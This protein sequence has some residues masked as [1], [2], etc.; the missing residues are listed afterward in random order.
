MS[1]GRVV[2]SVHVAAAAERTLLDRLPGT[3]VE[4]RPEYGV[5]LPDPEEYQLATTADAVRLVDRTAVAVVSPGLVRP[6]ELAE[7]GVYAGTFGL[8]VSVFTRGDD[9]VTTLVQAGAYALAV[10]AA[11]GQDNTLGGFARSS[12]WTAEE[13]VPVAGSGESS[14]TLGLAVVEFEVTVDAVLDTRGTPDSEGPTDGPVVQ[15]TTVTL[16]S[17]E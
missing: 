13:V 14:R 12:V 17:K 1:V 6:P 4:L 2:G 16:T 9:Y 10:R 5:E 15:R 7:D 8:V 3:L 11:V